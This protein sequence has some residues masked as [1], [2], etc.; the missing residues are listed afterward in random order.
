[1]YTENRH[2]RLCHYFKMVSIST[3][4]LYVH[5]YQCSNYSFKLLFA[6]MI[7][8]IFHFFGNSSFLLFNS[9]I[10]FLFLLSYYY[11]IFFSFLSLASPSIYICTLDR[12][13]PYYYLTIF[14]T[15]THWSR[16]SVWQALSLRD[17]IS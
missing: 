11:I 5:V 16:F 12:P 10:I 9:F 3:Q 14:T 4:N 1:M 17:L 7:L 15:A 6:N 8:A 2:K 13:H